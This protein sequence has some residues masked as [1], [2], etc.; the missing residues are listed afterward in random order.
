MNAPKWKEGR[1]YPSVFL[2]TSHTSLIRTSKISMLAG[3]GTELRAKGSA[4]QSRSGE[5][6]SGRV[7][8]K[9]GQA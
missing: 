9:T 2:H 6:L 5:T 4:T 1:I 7:S 3:V 8:A